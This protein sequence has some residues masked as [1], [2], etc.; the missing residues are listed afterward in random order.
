MTTQPTGGIDS[1]G[2]ALEVTGSTVIPTSKIPTDVAAPLPR[3]TPPTSTAAPT[4]NAGGLTQ[5]Q[6]DAKDSTATSADKFLS[7][8][9]KPNPNYVDPSASKGGTSGGTTGTPASIATKTPAVPAPI[10]TPTVDPATAY[11]NAEKSNYTTLLDQSS[12]LLNDIKA[13]FQDEINSANA[14]SAARVN[15]GGLA[16]STSGGQ[17]YTEAQKPIIDA[18]NIALDE[19]YQQIQSNALTLTSQSETYGQEERVTA[20][21]NAANSIKA[22]AQNALDWNAYKTTNPDNY[23]ALVS[24]VGGDPNVAD[25]M[26]ANSAPAENVVQTWQT[27]D[28]SGGTSI[29]QLVQDPVTGKQQV[30]KYDV[31]GVVIPQAWTSAKIGTN[32]TLYTSP[33]FQSDPSNPANWMT[34]STDPTNN[35]AIT[36]VANGV[37]TVNGIPV[38]TSL[39]ATATAGQ[40]TAYNPPSSA[41]AQKIIQ[42]TAT[43][44]G[45][46]DITQSMADVIANAN[47]GVDGVVNG[48]IKQEGG[49][50]A[51]VVNNPGNIEFANQPN[52]TDSGVKIQGGGGATFAS[53][54]TKQDGIDA[55]GKLVQNAANKGQSFQE[56]VSAYK[57]LNNP[58]TTGTVIPGTEG[59]TPQQ[60]QDAH[61]AAT[62]ILAGNETI[63]NVKAGVERKA[64]QAILANGT[65]DQSSYSPLAASRNTIAANRIVSN[66]INLPQ[67]QLTANGLPYLQRIQAAEQTPGSVS[68]Q[69]L[70][71]SLTKLNTAGN[72]ISDAQVK[73]IT[74]GQSYSDFANVLGNKFKEGGVLSD[75]QRKQISTIANAIYDNYKK[76]YQPVYDQATAQLQA[77]GIPKAF[78]TIP[79]LNTLSGQSGSDSSSVGGSSTTPSTADITQITS[80]GFTDN[81][82]GTYNAPD[83]TTYAYQGGGW[84]QQ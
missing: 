23:N 83:G 35:G 79:D 1:T 63:A 84:V 18:R 39:S 16:G 68:D 3:I 81:G 49:S 71:D 25:A 2:T 8:S 46:T 66:Y 31:P 7:G 9:G 12:G 43:F 72:A 52:A 20:L 33:N 38:N 53:F 45:V 73:I 21:T 62:E 42:D 47:V 64:V 60:L 27:P 56:F 74:D 58:T 17:I 50:P 30:V 15:A 32:S 13:S 77:A 70:L 10:P 22:L 67:Y 4:L 82:N 26:F 24:A 11:V 80:A 76:G 40:G 44:S 51:G 5:A 54:G 28:G 14:A 61:N 34:I 55:V 48:L 78:W 75:T 57:G 36:V 19:A 69:D 29:N 59:L 41:D 6:A 65:G 37:T